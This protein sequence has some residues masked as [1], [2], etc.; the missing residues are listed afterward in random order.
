MRKPL[1]I[2]AFLFVGVSIWAQDSIAT[3]Q[4]YA[5]TIAKVQQ[6]PEIKENRNA[7]ALGYLVG[8]HTLI[9]VDYEIRLSDYFGV[10]FGG[11]LL[12]YTAGVKIHTKPHK[13]SAFFNLN[14]K[15]SGF[16]AYQTAGVEYGV[17]W[18]FNKEKSDFGMLFQIGVGAVVTMS[19]EYREIVYADLEAPESSLTLGIGFCW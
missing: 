4:E 14:F 7:F 10:H 9:G 1:I 6:E 18:T 17:K 16:G 3:E 13:N 15:D 12:G 8:G 2:I 11:G 19:E 5:V